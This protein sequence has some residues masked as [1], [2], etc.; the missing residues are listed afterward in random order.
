MLFASLILASQLI[1]A[2]LPQP[3]SPTAMWAGVAVLVGQVIR[4]TDL[5]GSQ[6]T[7]ELLKMENSELTVSNAGTISHIPQSAVARVEHRLP[8]HAAKTGF[9]V[10]AAFGV[11][12]S[13]LF[14]KS[15]QQFYFPVFALG[16]GAVGTG[17]GAFT[18]ALDH[19]YEVVFSR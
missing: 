19:K 1:Q 16:W 15:N 8:S 5:R 7:G 3:S 13:A 11:V 6:I 18:G 14:V 12:Q 9:W 10:G 17:I 2:P 4:V